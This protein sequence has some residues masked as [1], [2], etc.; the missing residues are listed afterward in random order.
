M[1]DT[2]K[3]N[4]ENPKDSKNRICE[5][6][7]EVVGIIII[8]FFVQCQLE[9]CTERLEAQ[10]EKA[11]KEFDASIDSTMKLQTDMMKSILAPLK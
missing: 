10:N 4:S 9:R 3:K 2:E 5:I 7:A 11:L 6:I 8:L 1:S